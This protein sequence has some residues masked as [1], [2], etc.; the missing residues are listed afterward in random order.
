MESVGNNIDCLFFI[1]I[2][3][4]LTKAVMAIPYAVPMLKS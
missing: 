3:D 4:V 2:M 1:K